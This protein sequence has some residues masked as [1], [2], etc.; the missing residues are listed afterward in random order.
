MRV[1]IIYA[2]LC[3]NDNNEIIIRTKVVC[4]HTLSEDIV[5]GVNSTCDD[6]HWVTFKH[7]KELLYCPGWYVLPIM[8]M[9][10][11]FMVKVAIFEGGL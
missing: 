1:M 8:H 2:L 6:V 9:H 11:V 4:A 7:G 5:A 3:I 10:R